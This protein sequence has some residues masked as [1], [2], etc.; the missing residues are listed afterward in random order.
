MKEKERRKSVGVV[1]DLV[2]ENQYFGNPDELW[3]RSSSNSSSSG[4]SVSRL[5]DR[6]SANGYLE[7]YIFVLGIT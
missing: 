7:N 1:I 5:W 6:T 4:C 3:L 2:S